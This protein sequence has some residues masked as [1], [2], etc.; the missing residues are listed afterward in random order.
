MVMFMGM[1]PLTSIH[2]KVAITLV[3]RG[4]VLIFG[5]GEFAL[6]FTLDFLVVGLGALVAAVGLALHF[7]HMCGH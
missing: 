6:G 4:Y 7:G 1:T 5:L 2:S 3:T